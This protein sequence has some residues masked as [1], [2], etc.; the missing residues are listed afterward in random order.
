M[1]TPGAPAG[2]RKPPRDPPI[3]S[4][5]TKAAGKAPPSRQTDGSRIE[6]PLGLTR[7]RGPARRRHPG[8]VLAAAL[9]VAA[10]LVDS[11]IRQRG[12]GRRHRNPAPPPS[13]TRILSTHAQGGR[14]SASIF[15][16]R[17]IRFG[18][19]SFRKM[20]TCRARLHPFPRR[21]RAVRKG[22]ESRR[23]VS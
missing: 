21:H 13:S 18:K 11:P 3:E 22:R 16:R 15:H 10:A 8:N 23:A 14:N 12:P 17:A 20:N 2:S 9:T 4:F 1:A 19:V 6:N 5:G 7:R